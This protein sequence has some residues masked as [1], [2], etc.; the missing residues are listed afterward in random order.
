MK[1]LVPNLIIIIILALLF[2]SCAKEENTLTIAWAQWEPAN[3]LAKL[4]E[5]FTKE[6]GVKVD[7]VQIPW[8]S[9][10]PKIDMA[11]A[12][13]SSLYDIVIGDSQWLGQNSEAG[14]YIELTDWIKKEID[15]NSIYPTAMEAFAEYPKGSKKYWALPAEVDANGFCYRKDLFEDEKEKAAF[16][17]KYGV[18]LDV[19]KTYKEL[20]DIAEFFTRPDEGLYGISLWT[21]PISDGITMGV[22]QVLWSYGASLGDPKTYEVDGHINTP[23]AIEALEYYKG[24]YKFTPEGSAD[25]Y[26]QQSLDLFKS[27]QVAIAMN[28]FAFFPGLANPAESEYADKTGFF[29]APAGPK[30]R[31]IS[32]GGQGMSISAYSKNKDIAKQ[33]MKWF[34][35][36]PVQEKWAELG[37]F[38]PHK[39]VLESDAFMNATPFNKA[40]V[41]SFPHLRDFWAVPVYADLLNVCQK[42]WNAAVVGDMDAKEALDDIAQKH[43]EIFNKWKG[44]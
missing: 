34:I 21:T 1:R 6:T 30:G 39:E 36:K 13:K 24:L 28:F 8:D 35:Q 10:L 38:T 3:F 27:G 40:F 43:E 37:G 20:R 4:S 22:Q 29:A 41:E 31:Y 44:E 9:F 7:V 23:E 5:D 15:V 16:E 32:I 26:W 33:Y 18:P 11:F 17:K 25:V 19:P 42:N 2:T 12:G 14:H